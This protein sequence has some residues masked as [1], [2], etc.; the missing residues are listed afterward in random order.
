MITDGIR[1]LMLEGNGYQSK[2]FEFV[3]NEHTGK[4]LMIIGSKTPQN[5]LEAFEEITAIKQQFGIDYHYL[6]TLL[7][8]KD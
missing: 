6:E 5:R 7:P 8:N 1:A 3:S 4:N 2:V